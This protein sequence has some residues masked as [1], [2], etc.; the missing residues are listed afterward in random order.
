M[1]SLQ[2]TQNKKTSH[3]APTLRKERNFV[4]SWADSAG[5]PVILK[6]KNGQKLKCKSNIEAV[7]EQIFMLFFT[8]IV[9]QR[10]V[11]QLTSQ[12]HQTQAHQKLCEV[13]RHQDDTMDVCCIFMTKYQIQRI[14]VVTLG[15]VMF[16]FQ[17]KICRE[18]SDKY[19]QLKGSLYVF[20]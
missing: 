13:I 14:N 9:V 10:S 5:L 8:T 4:K 15:E 19:N 7:E 18:F 16:F 2:N 1:S 11:I 20:M 12:S 6:G 17:W 3:P